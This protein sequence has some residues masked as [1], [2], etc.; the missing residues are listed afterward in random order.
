MNIPQM[1][2]V[3]QAGLPNA[4]SNTGRN[5]V[6]GDGTTFHI[7]PNQVIADFTEDYVLLKGNLIANKREKRQAA[8]TQADHVIDILFVVDSEAY[9]KWLHLYNGNET[10]TEHHMKT[11]YH[12][13]LRSLNQR[14]G[15]VAKE[16]KV[17]KSLQFKLTGLMILKRSSD[18]SWTET[19]KFPTGFVNMTEAL[20]KLKT[21]VNQRTDLP[22]RDHV[23]AFSGYN[24]QKGTNLEAKG[25]AA[26]GGMCTDNS[27]SI[28][29][30]D[31]TSTMASVAAH[32][33]GHSFGASHDRDGAGCSDDD[34]Y[35]MTTKLRYPSSNTLAPRL[36]QFSPCSIRKFEETLNSVSCTSAN[37]LSTGTVERGRVEDVGQFFTADQQCKMAVGPE[38]NFGRSIHALEGHG[39]M[40]RGM[41]CEAGKGPGSNTFTVRIPL[42]GTSCGFQKWCEQG[43]CVS[44]A[45]APSRPDNCPQGNLPLFNCVQ[46]ECINYTATAAC[47]ETCPDVQAPVNTPIAPTTR[48]Y[49]EVTPG[50]VVTSSVARGSILVAD[51]PVPPSTITTA[52]GNVFLIGGKPRTVPKA[53]GSG[54]SFNLKSTIN[55]Q[56]LSPRP[57]QTDEQA[58]DNT[59]ELSIPVNPQTSITTP[60]SRNSKISNKTEPG[61]TTLTVKSSMKVK[62]PNP[63]SRQNIDHTQQSVPDPKVSITRGPI[64]DTVQV[65]PTTN[66]RGPIPHLDRRFHPMSNI[67]MNAQ[68]PLP[69]LGIFG[70]G[71]SIHIG[72]DGSIRMQSRVPS[73]AIVH[74]IGN[75]IHLS[76]FFGN[77]GA[78]LGFIGF[79]PR[80]RFNKKPCNTS[81]AVGMIGAPRPVRKST[82]NYRQYPPRASVATRIA[83]RLSV[84]T[85]LAPRPSVATRVA[86]RPSVAK[87]V[88]PRPLVAK[89]INPNPLVANDWLSQMT[90]EF[91][92]YINGMA[93]YLNN[94]GS[95]L[96]RQ[97]NVAA[98][99]INSGIRSALNGLGGPMGMW[100]LG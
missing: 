2:G 36:W 48:T 12:W 5:I 1:N 74:N 26:L 51:G 68:M 70:Q 50:E 80:K 76:G 84:A 69:G 77:P 100:H 10:K 39:D 19:S 31:M 53:Q 28:I 15:H 88:A 11:F 49:P 75:G 33:I 22:A 46:S 56:N 73:T 6:T 17:I 67:N 21:W 29:E 92:G 38:S 60:E 86:P 30:D 81:R 47:C 71:S 79:R 99:S 13:I 25:L 95:Q 41:Y 98:R 83:P 89:R 63:D 3:V 91:N 9:R 82:V 58:T 7:S 57:P 16:S 61:I 14:Y 62:G 85:V 78:S 52:D 90:R 23:M 66:S 32:E 59:P 54:T 93:R 20:E 40:C 65:P 24:L 37:P 87:K 97:M 72:H 44:N 35:I 42:D 43:Q 94:A 27:V 96:N 8:A 34:N 64:T 18:S 4:Q 55:I 45:E